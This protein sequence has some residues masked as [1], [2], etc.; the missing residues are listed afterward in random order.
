[1][2][3]TIRR[4]RKL[5]GEQPMRVGTITSDNGDGTVQV[6]MLDGGTVTV[7]GSGANG[8]AVFIK[9]GRIVGQAPTPAQ[10]TIDV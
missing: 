4:L 10:I 5:I 8:A 9:D 3:N 2:D 7:S 6:D 1:M